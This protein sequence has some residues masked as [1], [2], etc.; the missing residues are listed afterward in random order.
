M[1]MLTGGEIHDGVGTP[2]DR[3]DHFLDLFINRGG[4][5]GVTQIAIN[6]HTEVAANDHGLQLW[7]I[8]IGGDNGTACGNLRA[9]K[10]RSNH[11]R[12]IR[13]K[14]FA[15]MLL[16]NLLIAWILAKFLKAHGLAQSHVF[17]F[18]GDDAFAGVMHLTDVRT[19]LGNPRRSNV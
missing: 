15:R 12:N 8:N 5:G 16:E 17:H 6:L 4:H 18:R 7:V 10:L 9:Y 14:G 13:T 11:I 1:N 19:G 2:T 3:P